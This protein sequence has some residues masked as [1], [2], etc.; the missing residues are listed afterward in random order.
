[1]LGS[2]GCSATKPLLDSG[3]RSTLLHLGGM[4]NY[5]SKRLQRG[6]D[7]R[8]VFSYEGNKHISMV[9]LNSGSMLA[10]RIYICYLNSV[11]N[12]MKIGLTN[13]FKGFEL[14]DF[15]KSFPRWD[16]RV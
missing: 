8:G 9:G 13:T 4:T 14:Y 11:S 7:N 10:M 15:S 6:N 16:S 1:M 5:D 12:F 2:N 3:S